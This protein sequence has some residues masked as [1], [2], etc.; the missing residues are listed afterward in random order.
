MP[1]TILR[2]AAFAFVFVGFTIPAFAEDPPQNDLLN[3]TLWMQNAPEFKGNALTVFTLARIRLDQALADTKWTAAPVEQTGAFG[4]FPPAIVVDVDE[5][6]MDNSP[7]QAWQSIH[8]KSFDP[9]AWTAFVNSTTSRAIPGAVDF[10]KY[11]VSKGVKVFYVTNRTAEEEAGTRKNLELLGFPIDQS[12]D[13]VLTSRE[14]P[15]WGSAK[16]TRRAFIAKD[17]RILLNL[18]DNLSD[19]TDDYRGDEAA[20][21]KVFEANKD[22]WGREWIV[23]ANPAYGSFES[24]P[25]KHDFKQSDANKRKA[26]RDALQ[27]WAGP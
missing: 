13:T 25:Y 22:R 4:N 16:G 26:K 14:K 10:I 24:A 17:Y 5:T 11:A 23:V 7:F 20:R 2:A 15:D 19:F 21:A 12:M 18:G 9:K 6:I 3:A 8:D 27:P 1:K